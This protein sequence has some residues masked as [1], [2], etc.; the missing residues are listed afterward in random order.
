MEYNRPVG[1]AQVRAFARDIY[2]TRKLQHVAVLADDDRDGRLGS[3]ALAA[4]A[5]VMNAPVPARVVV[6][7]LEVPD[8]TVWN[9]LQSAQAFVIW[10]DAA[11]A[12]LLSVRLAELRPAAPVYLCR[13]A[14][15]QEA[16]NAAPQPHAEGE[17][18]SAAC[19]IAVAPATR[20][21]WDGFSKN[22]RRC[23]GVAPDWGAAEAYDAVRVLAASL[24]QSGPNR[25]RLRDAVSGVSA[26][27]GASGLISFDPAG[28]NTS[29]LELLRLP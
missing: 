8:E 23:F 12:D 16:I 4:A 28:N 29:P 15:D 2:Q 22:Y 1:H 6:R 14:T 18:R 17:S 3:E 26:F 21:A 25:A 13:K 11:M 24:R 20:E 19:W 9:E 10:T 27:A 5:R 7:H